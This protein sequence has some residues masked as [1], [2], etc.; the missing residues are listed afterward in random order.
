MNKKIMV[1]VVVLAIAGFI[2][3]TTLVA[4]SGCCAKK[5]VEKPGCVMEKTD[6]ASGCG[7]K[8]A[9][10]AP[11]CGTKKTEAA[12]GCGM[13]KATESKGCGMEKAA[14]EPVVE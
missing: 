10:E 7:V 14:K 9:T 13:K 6:A 3:A 8:T 12:S 5:A 2:T 4:G 1:F 11:G